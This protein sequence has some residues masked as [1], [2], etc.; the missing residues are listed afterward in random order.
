MQPCAVNRVARAHV[1]DDLEGEEIAQIE[2]LLEEK[3]T[4]R[5]TESTATEKRLSGARQQ[6]CLQ[7]IFKDSRSKPM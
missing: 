5:F 2:V 3:S 1:N 4:V 7:F 6:K